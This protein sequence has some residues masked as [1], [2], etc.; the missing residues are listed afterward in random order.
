[1]NRQ[2]QDVFA[3]QGKVV[4]AKA[5]SQAKIEANAVC[6]ALFATLGCGVG[7]RCDISQLRYSRIVLLTDPDVDGAHARALLA[8]LFARFLQQLVRGDRL[9]A[10][11]PPLWRWVGNNDRSLRY[12]WTKQ[13]FETLRGSD[14][15]S[16]TGDNQ[17]STQSR[18]DITR[19]RGVA[20]F[21]QAECVE[22]LLD[23]TSRRQVRLSLDEPAAA[24]KG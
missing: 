14:V 19:F 11:I 3:L 1:M 7:S 15:A 18:G 4:N 6:A 9:F 16:R 21:S 20:Q 22:L 12:A 13:E 8:T 24:I 2:T 10:V 23:P 5:A 17:A